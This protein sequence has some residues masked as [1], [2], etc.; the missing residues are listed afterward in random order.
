MRET[1]ITIRK[2]ERM[3]E[4]ELIELTRLLLLFAS[5]VEDNPNDQR[6]ELALALDCIRRAQA[7]RDSELPHLD[8]VDIPF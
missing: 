5:F 2:S 1:E 4:K 7:M 6:E 8:A 3:T